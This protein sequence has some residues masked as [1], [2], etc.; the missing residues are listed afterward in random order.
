[1]PMRGITAIPAVL[2]ALLATAC[3][4]AGG[5]PETDPTAISYAPELE[6]DFSEMEQNSAGVWFEEVAPGTGSTA[7]RGDLVR[8]HYLGFLP[9]GTV[10]D[11]SLGSGPLAFELGSPEVIR[12]WNLGIEGMKVGERRRMVLKPS[13]AY[14]HQG[15]DA[16][17]PNSVLV[18]EIQLIDAG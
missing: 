11:S 15:N 7:R 9:D 3:A 1:M 17:P 6:V 13:L 8:I 10:V 2:L 14:G 16:V 4:S 12:G 18:F 5:A